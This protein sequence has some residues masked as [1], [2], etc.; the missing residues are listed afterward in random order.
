MKGI[1]LMEDVL[2]QVRNLTVSYEHLRAP[3]LD[4]VSFSIVAGETCGLMGDSG[5]G[6]STLAL[7]L[8]NL[9]PARAR[10]L[11]G[12]IEFGGRNLLT[13]STVEKRRIRGASIALVAQDPEQALNP[14]LRVG[15]Q[16][17]EV[18]RNHQN[19]RRHECRRQAEELL[20]IVGL[21]NALF[22]RAYPHEVSG[23]QRQRVVLAQALAPRPA[24]LVADEPASALDA[25]TRAG[26]F[27]LLDELKVRLRLTI[28]LISHDPLLLGGFASRA[29]V[30]AEG[31]VTECQLPGG[32][33]CRAAHPYLS[34]LLDSLPRVSQTNVAGN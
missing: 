26:I 30:L 15:T 28:L 11:G 27:R 8:L 9:L 29:L 21:P 33:L 24:L 34:G 13:L 2:L 3:I 31:R 6:K 16:I 23:G 1:P 19:C 12:A 20:D 7:A 17:E 4:A 32:R 18:I 14:V 25:V 22:S 10:I 5:C